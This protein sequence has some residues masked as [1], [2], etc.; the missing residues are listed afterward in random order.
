MSIDNR[1]IGQHG[2]SLAQPSSMDKKS[3]NNRPLGQHGC[4]CFKTHSSVNGIVDN[5]HIGKHGRSRFATF[6]SAL[7]HNDLLKEQMHQVHQ[8]HAVMK[9]KVEDQSVTQATME[10]TFSQKLGQQ[11]NQAKRMQP[12]RR[13]QMEMTA[14]RQNQNRLQASP[15]FHK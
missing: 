2:R 11:C 14:R 10:E 13:T 7:E 9:N 12:P 6:S 5:G 1:P 3:T 8:A 15:L 4:S